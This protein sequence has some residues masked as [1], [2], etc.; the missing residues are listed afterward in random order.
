MLPS[1][2]ITEVKLRFKCVPHTL[3]YAHTFVIH[4]LKFIERI[5]SL[6]GFPSYLLCFN[7]FAIKYPVYQLDI[8]NM[9]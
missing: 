9:K 6:G 4:L 1:P 3:L 5:I 7:S 8:S 2:R